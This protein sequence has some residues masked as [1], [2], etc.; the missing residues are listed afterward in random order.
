MARKNFLTVKTKIMLEDFDKEVEYLSALL[1][2]ASNCLIEANWKEA[3][4]IKFNKGY[5]KNFY[6]E[7]AEYLPFYIPSRA[8]YMIFELTANTLKSQYQANQI[9]NTTKENCV[10]SASLMRSDCDYSI[11]K[12]ISWSYVAIILRRIDKWNKYY[13][14]GSVGIQNLYKTS[15]ETDTFFDFQKMPELS[16]VVLPYSPTTKH[17]IKIDY[18]S[19]TLFKNQGIAEIKLPEVNAV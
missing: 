16:K 13:W 6:D 10:V 11:F 18:N 14:I 8:K 15:L 1:N 2:Y 4:L 12:N 9:F 7:K 5:S 19:S 3:E 17:M